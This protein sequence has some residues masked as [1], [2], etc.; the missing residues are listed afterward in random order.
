RGTTPRARWTA[1]RT[2]PGPAAASRSLPVPSGVLLHAVELRLRAAAHQDRGDLDGVGALVDDPDDLLGDG[3]LDPLL[4]G[5]AEDRRR[6]LHALGDHVHLGDDR[7]EVA[8]AP[9]LLAH[10]PVA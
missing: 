6:G 5:D 3:H 8:P 9:E 10:V 2:G 1:R 7:V 4:P